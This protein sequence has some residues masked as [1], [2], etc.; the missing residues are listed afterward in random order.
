MKNIE[1]LKEEIEEDIN[2]WGG[3]NPDYFRGA[4]DAYENVKDWLNQLDEPEVLSQEWIDE[5]KEFVGKR[6]DGTRVEVVKEQ[7]LQNLLVP[8]PEEITEEQAWEVLSEAYD[9]PNKSYIREA[10]RVVGEHVGED[11]TIGELKEK[12]AKPVIPQFV[13]EVIEEHKERGYDVYDSIDL[14]IETNGG[15][16]PSI[17]NWVARN[18]DKYARAWLDG[19]EVAEEQEPRYYAK[20]KGH[21]NI[22]S[23]DKY[24]NYNTDMEELSVGDSEVHPNV[25][26]EYVLK[27]TKEELA[28]LGITDDNADFVLVEEMEE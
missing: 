23:N 24:W 9:I 26:S 21:E 20:I 5:H 1:W 28:N 17:S 22:A 2:S 3:G 7:Y 8:K 12:F 11:M 15:G 18:I 4:S 19:Y 27:A 6:P 13:A 10:M 16:L 14:I 25:I